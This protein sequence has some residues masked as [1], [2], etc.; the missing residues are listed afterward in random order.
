[1][2]INSKSSILLLK[3]GIYAIRNVKTNKVYIGSTLTN[4]AKRLQKHIR[5][6]NSN[7]HFNKHL[8]L[9]WDKYGDDCFEFRILMI[10]QDNIY[11]WEKR[12]ID[13]TKSLDNR[14]GYNINKN[15]KSPPT[16][17]PESRKRQSVS[18]KMRNEV[19]R[20]YLKQYNS[21]EISF[22]EIP[23]EYRGLTQTSIASKKHMTGKR[24]SDTSIFKVPHT[25]TELFLEGRRQYS[26]R[27]RTFKYPAIRV[28]ADGGLELG[29]FRSAKD[30]EDISKVSP[31][32]FTPYISGRFK[33]PR[34]GVPIDTLHSFNINKSIKNN[35]LYKGL[36]F[37]EIP[38]PSNK[39]IY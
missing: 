2:I 18:I 29:V 27:I 36:L 5:E 33:K 3:K 7:T 15:V 19:S 21:G 1:M 37:I 25:K 9:S 4:F 14:F 8:Q 23:I 22:D 24:Y 12:A 34:K 17:T 35:T 6:L 30:I 28:V 32:V 26:E 16:P 13:L 10:C 39:E 11:F 31:N 38:L 20:E